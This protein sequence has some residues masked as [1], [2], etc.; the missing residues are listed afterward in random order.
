[1]KFGYVR[2]NKTSS[3][4]LNLNKESDGTYKTGIYVKDT[5]TGIGTLTFIDPNSNTYGAL[6]H[7]VIDGNT[8][9]N[10]TLKSGQVFE[11]SIT[12]IT[13]SE[14]G[15]PGEKNAKLNQDNIYGDIKYNLET[16]IFG[17]LQKR[18]SDSALMEV[19]DIDEVEIGKA[20]IMTVLDGNKKETFEIE[21]LSIDKKSDTKNF[22]IK[23][24]DKDLI[25]STY[26]LKNIVDK[27]MDEFKI[28]EA[29][30][31][32]FDVLRKCNKY[33]DD[34]TPWILAKD[35]NNLDR[36]ET[37]LYNLLDSIRICSILLQ[38]F[39]PTTSKKIFDGLKLNAT[40]FESIDK[41]IEVYELG[42]EKPDNLFER[43]K[44]D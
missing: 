30:E 5:I 26:N 32:I 20:E 21:I 37:V 16:G 41:K 35:I 33:I 15:T 2:N 7:E 22:L 34:T 1:M 17:K 31:H 14:V 8:N 39:I 38:S 19:A 40:S 3:L 36:L 24:I 43:I 25:N 44:E 23:V 4:T 42:L 10:F 29:L 28:N 9:V 12:S 13:K 6:G 27:K 18:I 11:S